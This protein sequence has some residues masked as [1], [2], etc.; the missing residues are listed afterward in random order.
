MAL[1]WRRSAKRTKIAEIL[2]RART[3]SADGYRRRRTLSELD[4]IDRGLVYEAAATLMRSGDPS[5][6]TLAGRVLEDFFLKV[7]SD[8]PLRTAGRALL[9]E[10]CHPNQ[11]PQVLAAAIPAYMFV[12]DDGY[13]LLLELLEHPAP[14]VRAAAAE[15]VAADPAA[16]AD[17]TVEAALVRHFADDPDP[18]VRAKAAE[19]LQLL[20]EEA[21]QCRSR[22]AALF[23]GQLRHPDP[24]IRLSAILA[25]TV[26]E[27]TLRLDAIAAEL[28]GAADAPWPFVKALCWIDVEAGSAAVR[29]RIRR[30]L[31]HLQ[32]EKW[33]D[34]VTTDLPGP[35]ER[36]DLLDH[37]I[38][39]C[40]PAKPRR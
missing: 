6:M 19:G 5:S 3:Q 32:S 14:A 21:A 10:I 17:E 12:S 35:A 22:M 8:S 11:D 30:R 39:A 23:A 20:A 15:L 33:A 37:A 26:G 2:S 7:R 34:R 29:D 38:A 18:D 1:K 9:A 27:P 40:Q 24:R 36:E 4:G 31:L 13:K 16:M 25:T 28:G